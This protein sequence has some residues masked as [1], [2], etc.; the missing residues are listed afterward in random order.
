MNQIIEEDQD[1]KTRFAQMS[2]FFIG[3][4]IFDDVIISKEF[5]ED[6]EYQSR[7]YYTNI[8]TKEPQK[9]ASLLIV[10]GF[11]EH[12][13]RY[14]E[15]AIQFAHANLDVHLFDFR[16]FGYSSGARFMTSLT[17]LYEDVIL[18]LTKIFKN[19]P[20]FILAH[21]MGGGLIL[22][23][24]KMNPNLKIAGLICSNPFFDMAHDPLSFLE[25]QVVSRLPK[26]LD[27]I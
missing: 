26:S 18:V 6:Q 2:E 19:N 13:S 9:F 11:G 4:K 25:K 15:T 7:I 1:A 17:E 16:G 14:I 10:H 20:L 12:S 21:S 8:Q 5:V 27:V 24:L 3:R 23:F 22:N